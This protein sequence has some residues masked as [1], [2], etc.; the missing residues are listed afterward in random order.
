MKTLKE[1]ND[2]ELKELYDTNDMLQTKAWEDAYNDS[3]ECQYQESE[4]I[5]TEV[6]DY[7]DHYSSFYLTTPMRYG[8]KCPELVANKLKG[9]DYLT[10]ENAELYDKL[11]K[12]IDKWEELDYDEQQEEKGEKI[13]DE[14]I[15]VCDKLAEGITEQLRAYENTDDEQAFEEFKFQA[16]E[17]YMS[18]WT[19]DEKGEVTETIYKTYK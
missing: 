4:E 9:V 19:I 8:T 3:M 17:G 15:A 10:K 6:F 14:A 1:L 7:H 2:K 11:N 16:Q 12:L 13:Y 18:D 5:G